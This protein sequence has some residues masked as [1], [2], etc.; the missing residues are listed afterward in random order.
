MKVLDFGLAKI[1]PIAPT[2][3]I[4]FPRVTVG[5]TSDGIILG[6]AA[7]IGPEQARGSVV[8]KR[9]DIW[10]FGALLF[11]MLTGRQAF[12]SKTLSDT[13]ASVL[14]R[15][16][17]WQALPSAIP[18]RILDLLHR[19]LQK[20]P[21]R[22]LRDI[23]D[24]RI[25]IQE[26]LSAPAAAAF[27]SSR[28]RWR[29]GRAWLVAPVVLLV[30][31]A[32]GAS[33][34]G[35]AGRGQMIDSVAVLPFVNA[36]GDPNAEYL[37][38]GI[39]D[40][41]INT[42]SQ[43]PHLKVMSRDSA[44]VYKGKQTDARTVGRALGVRAV[45]TGRLTRQADHLDISAELVDARDG[46]HIWGQQYDRKVADM[47]A[48]REEIAREMT[49]ALRVRLTGEEEKR[50]TR[51]ETAN[52]EAYQDYLKG[53]YWWNKGTKAGFDKGIEYFHQAIAMDPTYARAYSGLADCYSSLAGSGLIPSKEG[54]LRA[55]DAALKALA[56]DDTLAEAHTSLALIKTSYDW[57]WSGADK[58]FQRAIELNPGSAPAH[59]LHAVGLWQTGRVD[60]AI[61][62][63]KRT[64]TLDPLS[65]ADNLT[66]GLE[67][68]LA[69][70]YDN[71][72]EQERKVLELDP[73]FG[74]AYYFRGMAYLKKSMFNE[75]MADFE[76]LVAIAPAS[77]G[78]VTALGYGYALTGRRTEAQRALDKLSELSKQKYMAAVWWAKIY[79]GLGRRTRPS[80]GWRGLSR[81]AL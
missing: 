11:E 66:L 26:A 42:L 65:L 23:G 60:A 63:S 53:R 17:D 46:S 55:K 76:K 39:T 54:Y 52:P 27:I 44:F 7:Y 70:Q 41:L 1:G 62:E 18:P 78:A 3:S 38:D 77:P 25:E 32:A 40:S 8:D 73:N 57:D 14:E 21:Q 49:S 58:E 74:N 10:A 29:S 37:S 72:I 69:R 34:Y 79:T 22:R 24:A 30:V 31:I 35:L 6:T 68:F 33:Y 12:G 20:D 48:L 9:A 81:T 28:P 80:S 43:L 64:L 13:I 56:L 36:S 45:F 19:C 71:A 51:S 61:A 15:E 5:E 16:P 59:R 2:R 4:A 67:F 47:V 75:A 50:L